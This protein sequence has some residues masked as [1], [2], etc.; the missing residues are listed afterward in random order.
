[1]M[2]HMPCVKQ[3]LS[4]SEGCSCCC[5][6]LV[7]PPGVKHVLYVVA[8]YLVQ[9]TC[10]VFQVTEEYFWSIRGTFWKHRGL[11]GIDATTAPLTNNTPH[12]N[13]RLHFAPCVR[14]EFS[15]ITPSDD[16][17]T[18]YDYANTYCPTVVANKASSVLLQLI[19]CIN[20]I[21]STTGI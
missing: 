1:M 18:S 7:V 5:G 19:F 9:G 8:N 11:A 13:S 14:V 16:T 2:Q 20:A 6:V 21:N 10:T 3:T 17:K 4:G 12:L 15:A